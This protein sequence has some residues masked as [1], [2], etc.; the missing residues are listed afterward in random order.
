[1]AWPR[2]SLTAP[3]SPR[4]VATH[5]ADA[6]VPVALLLGVAVV[7]APVPAPI[8]DLLL[9]ANLT[10]SVLAVLGALAARTPLD[11]SLFPTFLLGSTLVRLVLNVATTRLILARAAD[12]GFAAG[13]E[14]VRAFGE[15]VAANNLVV[16]G[17][18]FAI[19]AII[20][21]VV[22]TA[23]STRTSEVAARFALDGLPGRQQAI[24][25]DLHAGAINRDQAR[26]ARNELQRQ[27][28][29]FAS[30]DGASRFVRGEAVAG[31]VITAV[32]LVGGLAIGVLQR[33]MAP[34]KAVEVYSR[35]TIGDGLASA[36]PSLLVSV[37]TGLLISRSSQA[38]DL[39]RELGRQF[40]T[41]P[42]VLTV[43]AVFL[44]LL[45][46]SGL[47]FLPLATMAVLA[48]VAA[49]RS[50]RL[51]PDA[52]A[53]DPSP[54]TPPLRSAAEEVMADER[55]AIVLGRG[56]VTLV[57]GAAPLVARTATLRSQLAAEI[58]LVV[59]AVAFRDDTG[60][61]DRGYRIMVA[62]EEVAAGDIPAGCLLVVPPPG[63][64]PRGDGPEAAD[65]AS[66]R[67]GVWVG[68]AQADTARLRGATV[69]D[70][71]AFL[72]AG[73]EAGIRRHADRL[74]SRDAVGRLLES[75]RGT[76]PS[77]VETVVPAVLPVARIHRTLQA[78]LRDG[79]PIRPLGDVVEILADH[80]TTVTDPV[81]LAGL[82]RANLIHGVCRR[83]RDPA[84][85]LAVVR[86]DER[87]ACQLAE[88]PRAAPGTLARVRRAV[89]ARA[90]RGTAPV[91]VVPT[92]QRIAVRDA[93]AACLPRVRVLADTEIADED[94]VEVFATIGVEEGVR[95][96]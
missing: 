80:A 13:G 31:L 82:V 35:L 36:V 30:M 76:A 61:P 69:L 85:V 41:Q 70:A 77:L 96:A 40:A 83:S 17:V 33:G 29:F 86:L 23:G 58:G 46:L 93:L 34:G 79:L 51:Q 64:A 18:I 56:L 8:V 4:F 50:S 60:L 92:P 91:V 84:G 32:N 42:H 78:L 95:A 57:H 72:A 19:I 88:G 52:P 9:A 75:L 89:R 44:G 68:A 74:L 24:D 11:M 10:V 6:A 5:L 81:E 73:L 38:T 90:E 47:P 27:A 39:S 45:S 67:I 22:I 66:G 16:G 43:T 25:A 15:F 20:Q 48:G 1:M 94:R 59:P 12:D 21:L 54:A 7:L 3:I 87:A 26:Q 49:W 65:P 62:D 2:S 28:D 55:I 71:A 14:V 37:A 63:E 53:A